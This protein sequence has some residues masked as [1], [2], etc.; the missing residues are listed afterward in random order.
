MYDHHEGVYDHHIA[1]SM[2][3]KHVKYQVVVTLPSIGIGLTGY[4]WL[5]GYYDWL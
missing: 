2:F 3:N 4:D 1:M 5:C